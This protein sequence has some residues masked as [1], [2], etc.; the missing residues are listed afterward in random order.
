[1]GKSKYLICEIANSHN[2][3]ANSVFNLLK[4]IEKIK[5]KNLGLKFQII[6]KNHL[7]IK[8][9]KWFNVYKKLY[10]NENIWRKIINT[11]SNKFD[12]WLDIFDIY[13]TKILKQNLAKIYGI[14]LQSSVL[15]N[16][17]LLNELRKI[18]LRKK[19]IIIN[20]AGYEYFEIR[21]ILK[22]FSLI[23]I[24]RPIIQLGFQNF[25]TKK[26]YIHLN[27]INKLKNILK[28]NETSFADHLNHDDKFFLTLPLFAYRL[29]Y[30]YVE[31][32]ICLNRKKSRYDYQSAAEPKD[33]SKIVSIIN[34]NEFINQKN[35]KSYFRK[36]FNSLPEKKY[37]KNAMLL[38]VAKKNLIQ[39][40][41]ISENSL[42]FRRTPKTGLNFET[43]KKKTKERHILSKKIN[44]FSTLSN[45]SFEKAKIGIIIAG[46]T[47][48][49]RLKN[50]AL[51]K[52]YKKTSIERCLESCLKIKSAKKVILATSYLKSDDSIA[53]LKFKKGIK[54]FRGHP[55]DVIDRYIKAA[56]KYNLNVIIRG[57]ADCPYVSSEIADYLIESHFNSGADFTFASNAAPGTSVEIYNLGTLE[58]IKEKKPN[59]NLSEYMTWYVMNNAKFFNINKVILPNKLSRKYRLTLDYIE[60]LKF[61][62]VLFKKLYKKKLHI[63]LNN[64]FKI[65]DKNRNLININK[66]CKLVFKTDKKLINFLN[67]K[68]KF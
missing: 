39:N 41:L 48:S 13:G 15:D 1:M 31:K 9:Y 56:K 63:N 52:I 6:S 36:D 50:K 35:L 53:K 66:N 45:S 3:N 59:T 55:N 23:L 62:N 60:D 47:K 21:N 20:V 40:S 68:T 25:P 7:A 14:K 30:N 12:V 10:F 18:N 44:K 38:P 51:K 42:I 32:H 5:Y 67:K 29:K 2:G 54:T 61:F 33:L 8:Q 16:Q 19:K 37:L 43:I 65:L 26:R 28:K 27:K 22:R 49:K 24:N 57:T 34:Q 64:I 46:R 58:F 17:E 11:S 4:K